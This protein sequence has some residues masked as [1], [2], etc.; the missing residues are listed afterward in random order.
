MPVERTA[1]TNTPSN[2]R[3]LASTA[4]QRSVG[5]IVEKLVRA[6]LEFYPICA[7]KSSLP[8]LILGRAVDRRN[9]AA[10][11]AEVD[12]ELPA[13]VDHVVQHLPEEILPAH[14]AHLLG[15]CMELDRRA[16][17]P[18]IHVA[19]RIRHFFEDALHFADG[20]LPR[21]R[22]RGHVRRRKLELPLQRL[23]GGDAFERKRPRQL[24]GAA[25]GGV[26][27]HGF[28]PTGVGAQHLHRGGCLPFPGVQKRLFLAHELS[29]L[30]R[31]EI[32]YI[33]RRLRVPNNCYT[34]PVHWNARPPECFTASIPAVPF[35]SMCR[36]RS[37]CASRSRPAHWAAPRP[38]HP[39]GSC[40]PNCVSIRPP[41]LKR[42]ATS[43]HKDSW[44]FGM[45]PAR[46]CG[47]WR[48]DAGRGS[49][50]NKPR[51]SCENSWP[52][53]GAPA[54]RWR[55]CNAPSRQSWERKPHERRDPHRTPALSRGESIRDQR[56]RSPRPDRVDLRI[57]RPEWLGQDHNHS[58]H[59]GP[60][61]PVERPY[62]GPGR[63]DARATRARPSP[64]RLRAGATAPRCDA[65]RSRADRFPGSLLPAVGSRPGGG[66]GPALRARWRASVRSSV[67]RPE[68]EAHDSARAG[69]ARRSARP[70]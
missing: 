15:C 49:D 54:F 58:P 4:C 3:S 11:H 6:P 31:T 9:L 57:C 53:R 65:H 32:C 61:P 25:T 21:I 18:I 2:R 28:L 55:S 41:S 38:F 39:C 67:Q 24:L 59:L 52:K 35:L 70:G 19:D 29:S 13:M 34:V 45:V 10:R 64:G 63:F 14:V 22:H 23:R 20:A 47:S 48:L 46:S 1:Y 69:A 27:L 8:R 26:R 66:A 51:R 7:L 50:R 37:A 30:S 56:A 16:Q 42:T 60:A 44:R 43:R 12:R 5:L 17:L 62:H 36:S 33:G 68:G 40:P